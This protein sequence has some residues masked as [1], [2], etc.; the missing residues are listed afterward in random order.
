M[1]IM[2]R[3][4]NTQCHH[5]VM[6]M[7]GL[8]KL[9]TR[10]C[11]SPAVSHNRAFLREFAL[12]GVYYVLEMDCPAM[13]QLGAFCFS[14]EFQPSELP[15]FCKLFVQRFCVGAIHYTVTSRRAG[16]TAHASLYPILPCPVLCRQQLLSKCHWNDF[17]VQG[18]I[19]KL[20]S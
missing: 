4:K 7:C 5:S 14:V 16:A 18:I 12:T 1:K 11:D 17:F 9:C 10:H 20:N 8:L 13:W 2:V 19:M 3:Q 6:Q 15:L